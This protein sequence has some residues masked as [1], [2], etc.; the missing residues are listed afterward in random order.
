M[1]K[2]TIVLILIALTLFFTKLSYAAADKIERQFDVRDFTEIYLKGPY[3]V[4][5]HQSSECGLR[6]IADQEFF[7][8]LEVASS[9]GKLSIELEGKNYKNRRS[10]E[11]YIHFK[12]LQ[13]LQIVGAVDLNCENTIQVANLKL[14]FEGAGN[15]EL[16][17]AVNKIISVISGVGNFQIKGEADYHKVEFSG[18]GKY[19][20]R[21]LLS[22]N[23]VVESNGIGSVSVFASE[24]F[25]GEANG[26]G[27][28]NYYGDPDDVS[29]NASGLGSVKR[30]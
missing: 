19:E 15:V 8:R 5:L 27:S 10:I 30:Q 26:I 2:Y 28:V 21:N 14:E 22:K 24:K 16:N 20:A 3:E 29:I 25:K 4:H 7:D 1:K 23:T 11:V 9:L 18:I 6:I 13:K 17:V 12:D